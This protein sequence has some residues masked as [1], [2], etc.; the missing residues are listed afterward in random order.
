MASYVLCFRRLQTK[1][2]GLGRWRAPVSRPGA[3]LIARQLV[4]GTGYEVSGMHGDENF[5]KNVV[6]IVDSPVYDRER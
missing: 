4:G 6:E 3:T 1:P 2:S 5:S